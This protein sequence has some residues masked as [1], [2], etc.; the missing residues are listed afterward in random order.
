MGQQ[1]YFIK[2]AYKGTDFFGWQVQPNAITVQ[3]TLL[4][5]LKKL[6]RNRPLK[7][8]GCGRTDTGVHASEF[9]AHADFEEDPFVNH[10]DLETVIHKL[11]CMLPHAIAIYDL[12]PVPEYLHSRFN[13]TARTY[14][15]FIHQKK[16]PFLH[17]TSWYMK[18]D[19][20][21]DAMNQAAQILLGEHNFKCFS[22]PITGKSTF[23]CE[24]H[25]ASW[26][27]TADGYRFTIKANRF[28][29]NMVR[30]IVGTMIE[31]GIKKMN[32]EEFKGVI[33]SQ[34]RRNAGK[35]AP[36]KGLFL[37]KVTYEGVPEIENR[38]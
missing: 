31:I 12:F 30:A 9:Y 1:R 37:A 28:L 2:L 20:D 21:L 36:A 22:K 13:A 27:K 33:K 32:L 4:D 34:D 16:S 29:R 26:S 38:D 18:T 3:E 8:T 17:E 24:I 5:V 19:L 35:S 14:D 11:N 25:Q 15:Y 7:L 10:M 23:R 6:N